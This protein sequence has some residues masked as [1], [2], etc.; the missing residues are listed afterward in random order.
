[1]KVAVNS[2]S[3][4][5][6]VDFATKML[7]RW[8]PKAYYDLYTFCFVEIDLRERFKTTLPCTADVQ[9]ACSGAC[10]DQTAAWL[11]LLP[12][13]EIECF[14]ILVY[15]LLKST[16]KSLL[17]TLLPNSCHCPFILNLPPLIH[18]EPIPPPL[19][20]IFKMQIWSCHHHSRP[21][22][23]HG[24]P[25]LW[26]QI[27]DFLPHQDPGFTLLSFTL[28]FLLNHELLSIPALSA[29]GLCHCPCLS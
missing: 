10:S 26:G 8:Q 25:A 27:L 16:T 18:L 7:T 28:C 29:S 24:I 19:R 22:L 21:H 11:A 14:E 6:A 3:H 12:P 2:K 13:P 23:S 9:P 5:T 4:Q 1:M 17:P 15:L 20:E